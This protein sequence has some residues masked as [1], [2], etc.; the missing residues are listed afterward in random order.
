MKPIGWLLIVAINVS[1]LSGVFVAASSL[2]EAGEITAKRWVDL[3]FEGDSFIDPSDLEIYDHGQTISK[4]VDKG[5]RF[6]LP[7]ISPSGPYAGEFCLKLG[8]KAEENENA[9]SKFEYNIVKHHGNQDESYYFSL[10][11]GEA[12]YLGFALKLDAN[13]YQTPRNWLLHMQV[14]QC[15]GHRPPPLAMYIIPNPDANAP[16][17]YKVTIRDDRY[18]GKKNPEPGETSFL[19]GKLTRGVWHTFVFKL[20]PSYLGQEGQ[21]EVTMW[22]DGEQKLSYVGKWGYKPETLG[23]ASRTTDRLDIKLGIYRR[24]QATRQIIYLDNI[25]YG[26]SKEAVEP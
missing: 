22:Q 7:V 19:S 16:V 23:G 6:D 3:G 24:R 10:F 9:K 25:R 1:T 8:V 15:C 2:S 12:R 26:N 20:K 14:W 13:N 11:N 17:Q 21:G 4:T 5:T 18:K